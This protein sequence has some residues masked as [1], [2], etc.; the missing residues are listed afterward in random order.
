M[1]CLFYEKVENNIAVITGIHYM[2]NDP[3][4]GLTEEEKSKGI[5]IDDIPQA[6]EIEGKYSILKI[7]IN[8]KEMWYEY[9]DIPLT[10][11]QIKEQRLQA[12]EIAMAEMLGV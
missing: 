3:I 6:E 8:T 4:D 7:N 1:K 5:M 2:P 11:E 10:E 12:L 9:K